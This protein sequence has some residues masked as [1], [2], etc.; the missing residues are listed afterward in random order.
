MDDKS[1]GNIKLIKTKEVNNIIYK[2]NKERKGFIQRFMF[3]LLNKNKKKLMNKNNNISTNINSIHNIE[4]K[5]KKKPKKQRNVGI[6][7]IRILAMYGIILNHILYQ[8]KGLSKYKQ[9]VKELLL[10]HSLSF[11]HND[12][13]VLISGVIGYKSN[14]YSNLLYLW[15]ET[16]FYSVGIHLYFQKFKKNSIIIEKLSIEFFP[17]VYDRYWY[18]T[19]Y[20]GMFLFLPIINKGIASLTKYEH[21]L[22][23]ISTLGIF[24][25]WRHYKNPKKDIF[26][27]NRGYSSLWFITFFITGSYIG[28][29]NINYSG[30]K[31]YFFCFICLFIYICCI[32][33][34]YKLINNQLYNRNGSYGKELLLFL[35]YFINIDLDG[36]FKVIQSISISLFFLNIQYNKYLSKIICFIGPLTFGVYLIHIHLIIDRNIISKI[37]KNDNSNLSLSSSIILVLLKDL[38]IFGICIIIE[39]IRNIIFNFLKIKKICIFLENKANKLFGE[40]Q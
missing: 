7:L 39:Y 30:K 10:L 19:Q 5:E 34:Y 36:F 17:V 4:N 28:K 23:V 1:E 2:K 32:I 24:T 14:K 26:Y 40:N 15:L 13:F 27:L 29:Y 11:W 38:K 22:I 3:N 16:I 8:G 37:F 31:R 18:F 6:D 9:Y 21:K 25:F 33:F 12:G 35:K 20:F